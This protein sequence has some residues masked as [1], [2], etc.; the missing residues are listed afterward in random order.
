MS[1]RVRVTTR[2][3]SLSKICAAMVSCFERSF[4]KSES[5]FLRPPDELDDGEAAREHAADDAVDLLLDDVEDLLVGHREQEQE[6]APVEVMDDVHALQDRAGA[7]GAVAAC[8]RRASISSGTVARS[9]GRG[10]G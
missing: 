10:I 1:S 9:T 7:H 8:R 4:V 3:R 5:L 6:L 2:K